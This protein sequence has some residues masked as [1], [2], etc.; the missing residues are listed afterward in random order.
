MS[1]DHNPHVL[2]QNPYV[3]NSYISTYAVDEFWYQ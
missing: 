3:I 2:V 1:F